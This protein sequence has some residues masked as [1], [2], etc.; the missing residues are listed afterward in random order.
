MI[1]YSYYLKLTTPHATKVS[2]LTFRKEVIYVGT[3][4]APQPDGTRQ[5]FSVELSDLNRW[6]QSVELQL[7]RGVLIDV[8]KGHTTD[9]DASKGAV[10]GAVVEKNSRGEPALFLDIKFADA[11]AAKLA[12]TTQVSI[13]SPPSWQDGLGNMYSRP[14]RHVALTQQPVIPK[15]DAFTLIASLDERSDNMELLQQICDQ[16][17]I[18][19]SPEDD[20]QALSDLIIGAF[21]EGAEPDDDEMPADDEEPMDEP[22]DEELS[23][24]D[25]VEEDDEEEAML[26]HRRS[27]SLSLPARRAIKA[28]R[29]ARVSLLLSERKIT[30][31]QA[32]HLKTKHCGSAFSLSDNFDDTVETLAL[33]EPRHTGSRTG[34]QL[35]KESGLESNPLVAD[36]ARRAKK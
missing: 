19:Y 36:A 26:S 2:G 16:I 30:P 32:K 17:G 14:I 24:D 35:R 13:F 21:N 9:P 20:E 15:L 6:K 23:E 7:E 4:F 8:P 34:A 5:K 31:A 11:E 22:M 29:E 12:K 28:G 18:S 33:S 3:F 10:V 25:I 27:L 1:D